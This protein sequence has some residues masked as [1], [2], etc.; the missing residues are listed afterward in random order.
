[1]LL[2]LGVAHAVLGRTL[3]LIIVRSRMRAEKETSQMRPASCLVALL[4]VFILC[5]DCFGQSGQ[6]RHRRQVTVTTDEDKKYQGSFVKADE[7]GVIIENDDGQTTIKIDRVKA[8]FFGDTSESSLPPLSSRTTKSVQQRVEAYG[9]TFEFIEARMSEGSVICELKITSNRDVM[10][11]I[12]TGNYYSKLYDENGDEYIAGSVQ[13]GNKMTEEAMLIAGV[14]VNVK[15]R[16]INVPARVSKI[17]LLN[18]IP[19]HDASVQFRNIPII[20]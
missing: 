17:T 19:G 20:K 16:F 1:V 3:P 5:A 6:F 13:I 12:H 15:L 10:I 18:L 8:I 7:Y 11:Y 9:A 4:A 14:P 2:H